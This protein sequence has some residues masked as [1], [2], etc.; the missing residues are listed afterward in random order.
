MSVKKYSKGGYAVVSYKVQNLDYAFF[1]CDSNVSDAVVWDFFTYKRR[2]KCSLVFK[3]V[4]LSKWG[5][6]PRNCPFFP[7][8]LH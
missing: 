6:V 5:F 3:I 2:G 4:P 7:K 1:H 8:G